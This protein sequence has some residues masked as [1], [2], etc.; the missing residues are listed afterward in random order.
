MSSTMALEPSTLWRCL[1]KL[2][3]LPCLSLT[4]LGPC[5]GSA[6]PPLAL[7]L[8]FALGFACRIGFP[9]APFVQLHLVVCLVALCLPL[10]HE[11]RAV[12]I[13]EEE[14]FGDELLIEAEA[15]SRHEGL[16]SEQQAFA[17]SLRVAAA[18]HVLTCDAPLPSLS[19]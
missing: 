2:L 7:P 1:A 16:P 19:S 13:V 5:L 9:A 11:Q 8:P 6:L 10:G 14:P 4:W 3:R 17:A 12:G 18:G 15:V